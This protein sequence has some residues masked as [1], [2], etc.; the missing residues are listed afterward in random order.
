MRWVAA[1]PTAR[2]PPV[3]TRLRF[4]RGCG[5]LRRAVADARCGRRPEARPSCEQTLAFPWKRASPVRRRTPAQDDW[6]TSAQSH[7][8]V[9]ALG[10]EQEGSSRSL[11]SMVKRHRWSEPCR[12]L[13]LVLGGWDVATRRAIGITRREHSFQLAA[14][15]RILPRCDSERRPRSNSCPSSCST[16]S[17]T[18]ATSAA[19]PTKHEFLCHRD[20]LA[21]GRR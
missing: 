10:D 18:P 11:R 1:T 21:R 6:P 16:I 3:V 20:A 15:C 14:R 19:F 17:G 9:L 2:R 7:P 13:L 5:R 4:A 12:R 8:Q